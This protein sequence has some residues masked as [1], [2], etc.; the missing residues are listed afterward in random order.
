MK[1]L[2]CASFN[3]KHCRNNR[4]GIALTQIGFVVLKCSLTNLKLQKVWKGAYRWDDF[5]G[6]FRGYCNTCPFWNFS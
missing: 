2:W 6:S 4:Y 5:C 1:F 3:M